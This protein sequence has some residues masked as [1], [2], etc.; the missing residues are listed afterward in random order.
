[1]LTQLPLN[2]TEKDGEANI[3][4]FLPAAALSLS[5]HSRL[6][7]ALMKEPSTS[8]SPSFRYASSC[9]SSPHPPAD[10]TLDSSFDCTELTP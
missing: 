5:S 1:M 10:W 9:E 4:W 6:Q 2:G 3:F 8:C 7:F